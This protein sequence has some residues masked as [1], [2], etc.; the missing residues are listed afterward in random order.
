MKRSEI[1][2]LMQKSYFKHANDPLL[3]TDKDIWSAVLL[4]MEQAGMVPPFNK[5]PFDRS[6]GESTM[7]IKNYKWEQ[8]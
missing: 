7:N 4:D 2:T 6:L 5:Q 1:I 8:E 3:E